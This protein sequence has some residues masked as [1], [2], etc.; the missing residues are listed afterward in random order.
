MLEIFAPDGAPPDPEIEE[1]QSRTGGSR[2]YPVKGGHRVLILYQGG[3]YNSER[4]RLA[5][6]AW[7]HEHCSRCR[8]TIAPMALCWVTEAGPFLLLDDEC[9]ATVFGPET[10]A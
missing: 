7:D 6:G 2:W 5:K 8:K 1:L 10:T 3:A 9:H 4:F